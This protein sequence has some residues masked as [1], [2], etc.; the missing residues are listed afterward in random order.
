MVSFYGKYTS[1]LDDKGRL[2]LPAPL[3]GALPEGGDMRFVV[4]KDIFAS[5]LEMYTYEEWERQAAEVRARLNFFNV[6]HATFWRA[7]MRDCVIV[8]PDAKFGRITISKELLE[9]I[10]VTKEVEFVG[11]G[12]KIEIWAKEAY[13]S[14]RISNEDF[15]AIAGKLPANR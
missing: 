3:K 7:Y 15:V 5:C 4:R 10:G 9:S 2:V 14:S 8:E 1:K 6:E 12:F 13:E 11:N